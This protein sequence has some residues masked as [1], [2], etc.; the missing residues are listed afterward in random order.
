MKAIRM[1]QT[2]DASVLTLEELPDPKPAPGQALVRVEAAGINF[3]EVYQRR[4][5]NPVTLPYTFGNEGAGS[6]VAVGAGVTTVKPGDLVA[7]VNLAGSYAELAVSHADRL[8]PVPSGVSTRDAAAV[9]LQGIT[10]HYLAIS[11]Y[12]LSKGDWCLIHAVAGGTGLLLCQIAK[13]RGATVIGTTSTPAKA[14]LAREA[15]ADYVILYSQQEVAPEVRRLTGGKGV[16]VVYDSV[17]K[18][19]WEGSLDS[20]VP[21]G[22]MVLFGQSSGRVDPFDPQTLNRKGSLYLTRPT[23]AHYTATREELVAR[24]TD[25]FNWIREGTLKVRAEHDFPLAEARAAHVALE[26]RGTTG[27]LLLIP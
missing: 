19:T 2:G 27:K 9:L 7:S 8:V 20:L 18:T 24:T 13:R 11:T 5:W 12:P 26:S 3:I 10:A 25:L 1:H 6:V 21:R 17:G 4:G 16:Q 23:I 15:G 14:A 22:M